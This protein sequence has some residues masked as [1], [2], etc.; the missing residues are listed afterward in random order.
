VK[1]FG[2]IAKE[3]TTIIVPSNLSDLASMV[4]MATSITKRT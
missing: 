2:K 3:S 1:Q 4:T